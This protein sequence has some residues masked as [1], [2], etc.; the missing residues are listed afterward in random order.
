MEDRL[1]LPKEKRFSFHWPAPK[2]NEMKLLHYI[3]EDYKSVPSIIRS[4]ILNSTHTLRDVTRNYEEIEIP[5]SKFTDDEMICLSYDFFDWLPNPNYK[6]IALKMTDRNLHLLRIQSEGITNYYGITYPFLY[7]Y[8]IPYVLVD[9]KNTVDDFSTLN[10]EIA[11]CIFYHPNKTNFLVPD[12]AY[13]YELEGYFFDFLSFQFLYEKKIISEQI[14]KNLEYVSLLNVLDDIVSFYL[15]YLALT[16]YRKEKKIRLEDVVQKTMEHQFSFEID[17]YSFSEVLETPTLLLVRD[18]LSFLVSV[19]LE[20]QYR[21]DK[22]L[23]FYQF[24]KI[25]INRG[26]SIEDILRENGIT[27]MEDK[28]QN[29]RDKLQRL[30]LV[31]K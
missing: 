16:L 22:D 14:L 1:Y 2:V 3:Q 29:V 30:D 26:Q 20:K 21:E 8:Y 11:H 18:V 9:K 31:K 13:L 25:R 12:L 5:K 24:E 6:K 27:F 17:P 23:A 28:Y 7:P 15:Q 4:W 19:D 10:H